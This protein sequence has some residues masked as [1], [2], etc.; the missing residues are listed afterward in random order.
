MIAWGRENS[1]HR[2]QPQLDT[3]RRSETIHQQVESPS[4]E[5][6]FR[7]TGLFGLIPDTSVEPILMKQRL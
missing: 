1:L 5:E 6:S 4:D 7:M 3:E 2:L